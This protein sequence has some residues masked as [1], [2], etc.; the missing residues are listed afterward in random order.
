[1]ETARNAARQGG[2]YGGDVKRELEYRLALVHNMANGKE[3]AHNA[4]QSSQSG[5]SANYSIEVL[6]GERS[7]LSAF[8]D[9]VEGM[10]A[11]GSPEHE[12][13]CDFVEEIGRWIEIKREAQETLEKAKSALKAD[14]SGQVAFL[15]GKKIEGCTR[16]NVVGQVKAKRWL[17]GQVMV[18][19]VDWWGNEKK[20]QKSDGSEV[21]MER[22]VPRKICIKGS[23][24]EVN[25]LRRDTKS[26]ITACERIGAKGETEALND[27]LHTLDDGR[28]KI[29]NKMR[30]VVHAKFTAYPAP[31]RNWQPVQVPVPV[32]VR[33]LPSFGISADKQKVLE[34]GLKA[35]SVGW[36]A[37]TI[38]S[39]SAERVSAP[40]EGV[41]P[42]SRLAADSAVPRPNALNAP[43]HWD[44]MISYTQ[45]NP[46]SETLA[47]AI[48]S[49]LVQRGKRVWLDV[50]MPKR[51]EAAMR[52]GVTHSQCVIAIVS[53]PA[54]D[55]AAY[56]R[57]PFCLSELRWALEA[58]VTV[59][60]V[61]AAE[62]KEQITE[63][64]ADIPEDLDHLKGVNWE[65][66]D[67][68]DVDYFSLGVDKICRAGGISKATARA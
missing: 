44:S 51:D 14:L 39:A 29:V 34:N 5:V 8:G 4:L 59:V 10:H 67:R 55:K 16:G 56:F 12:A 25:D 65:H 64:F 45:R 9:E 28:S 37:V 38:Q 31:E 7:K 36:E 57:R 15:A 47:H 62:D 41:P 53:G 21:P 61:V 22:K 13:L 66:I 19:P 52:E 6:D 20:E 49:E 46:T 17:D 35:A 26:A 2:A 48:H 40:S 63:L 58:S 60:P 11:A 27:V 1:M 50:K 68:K 54:G 42:S 33:Q 30:D 23:I 18:H 43:G 24:E 3:L 32:Q